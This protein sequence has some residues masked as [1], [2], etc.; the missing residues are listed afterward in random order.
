MRLNQLYLLENTIIVRCMDTLFQ[1]SEHSTM[2]N[3][4]KNKE[5]EAYNKM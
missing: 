2:T 5:K 1:E 3:W 4:T